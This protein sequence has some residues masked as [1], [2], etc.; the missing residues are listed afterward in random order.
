MPVPFSYIF[1]G[2][3]PFA[4]NTSHTCM[5]YGGHGNKNNTLNESVAS[6]YVNWEKQ[7][8]KITY[9][10]IKEPVDYVVKLTTKASMKAHD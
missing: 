2:I 9:L 3:F 7:E 1:P 4:F 10:V 8:G 5:L 6:E